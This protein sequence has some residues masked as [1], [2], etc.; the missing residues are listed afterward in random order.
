MGLKPY[1]ILHLVN[2][3]LLPPEKLSSFDQK[4][5]MSL[6]AIAQQSNMV[7]SARKVSHA[8]HCMPESLTSQ[9]TLPGDLW[10]LFQELELKM[11][12]FQAPLI[13]YFVFVERWERR[14]FVSKQK[15]S[16]STSAEPPF[17]DAT[18]ATQ[19]LGEMHLPVQ[20]TKHT[21]CQTAC[22]SHVRHLY[23][24]PHLIPLFFCCSP[25]LMV[26]SA[27]LQQ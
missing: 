24:S 5:S 26:A 12:L 10:T 6:G 16:H 22:S 19:M 18:S 4:L 21:S 3:L 27:T 23:T 13:I 11:C 1:N 2:W 20:T 25:S 8:G 9:Q 14:G 7:S 17:H 15:L